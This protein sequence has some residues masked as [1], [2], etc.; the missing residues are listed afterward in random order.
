[1]CK[2]VVVPSFDFDNNAIDQYEIALHWLH[3]TVALNAMDPSELDHYI[4]QVL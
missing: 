3:T 1:M 4:I 2:V